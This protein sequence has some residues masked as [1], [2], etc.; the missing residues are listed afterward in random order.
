[1]P[2]SIACER[3]DFLPTLKGSSFRSSAGKDKQ[4]KLYGVLT[5]SRDSKNV[6][7]LLIRA[8]NRAFRTKNWRIYRR[9]GPVEVTLL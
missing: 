3:G 1:M 4:S 7:G 8:N 2:A 6:T 5:G 9:S